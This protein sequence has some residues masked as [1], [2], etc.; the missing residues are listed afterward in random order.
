[1]DKSSPWLLLLLFIA[2]LAV[3]SALKLDDEGHEVVARIAAH[4]VQ[5]KSKVIMELVDLGFGPECPKSNQSYVEVKL[6]EIELTKLQHLAAN[7]TI[8]EDPTRAEFL[9]FLESSRS[10]G[11]R[12]ERSIDPTDLYKHYH[13]QN[14]I[15]NFLDEIVLKC[16]NIARKYSI[17]KTFFGAELW[18]IRITDNPG[19]QRPLN[20]RNPSSNSRSLALV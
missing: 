8:V 11:K 5:A 15:S 20:D 14:Q 3:A 10:R 9:R 19:T 1:M 2:I 7:L 12:G 4:D 17:G 16:P 18:A 13:D 6:P